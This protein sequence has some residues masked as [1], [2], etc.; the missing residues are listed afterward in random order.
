[1]PILS[2]PFFGNSVRV[3]A[4]ALATGGASLG[5]LLAFKAVFLRRLAG[6]PSLGPAEARSTTSLDAITGTVLRSTNL[7]TIVV[8]SVI[9]GAQALVLGGRLDRAA[10]TL[11]VLVLLVQAG[12][13]ANKAVGFT[14]ALVLHQ[15]GEADVAGAS[16]LK[17]VGMAARIAVWSLLLLV[18]L[19]RLGVNVTG[20]VAGLGIG[21]IAVALA[22]QNILGDLL[23][24]MSIMLDKPFEVGD[25]ITT[26]DSLGVVE[27]IGMKTTRIRSLSGE[28]IIFSNSDLLKSRVRNF[29]RMTERRVVL[30]LRVQFGT[31]VAKLAVIPALLREIVTGQTG[32]R[33]D[34]AHFREIGEAALCFEIVY[35]VLDPDYNHYM[36]IQQAINFEILGRFD[37][38]GI[39]FASTVPGQDAPDSGGSRTAPTAEV[40]AGHDMRGA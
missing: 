3:W 29:K 33:L 22:L 16:T 19:D 37:A 38:E 4:V 15:R 5:V 36:D 35:F 34:R 8:V 21:G 13:W 32:V 39:G 40:Q 24:A 7:F 9:L 11:A 6:A 25:F 2:H 27:H 20:L 23:S 28:Q 18:A 1:M 31:P 12:L 14:L 30:T 17:A 26:G 10:W